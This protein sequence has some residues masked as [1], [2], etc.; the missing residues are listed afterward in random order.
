MSLHHFLVFSIHCAMPW[1][2]LEYPT[3][4]E[5]VWMSQ[6]QFSQKQPTLSY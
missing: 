5:G 6:A 3:I 4:Y 1:V 2:I